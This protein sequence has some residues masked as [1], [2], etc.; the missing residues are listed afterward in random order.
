MWMLA[1][2][3]SLSLSMRTSLGRE[4][5]HKHQVVVGLRGGE[6]SEE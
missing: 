5:E 2:A 3:F 1:C 6:A 4:V